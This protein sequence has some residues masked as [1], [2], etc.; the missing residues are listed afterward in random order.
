VQYSLAVAYFLWFISGFGMLGFH[1]FYLGKV[2]SGALWFLTGGF[3]LFGAIT[4]FFRLPGLVQEANIRAGVQAA[5]SYRGF[6]AFA[7][8]P[9]PA[10]RVKETP[11][12]TILRVAR[13]NGGSVTPGEVALEG[14]LSIEE[15]RKTLDKLAST[16]SAEMRVRSSGVVV[17]FFPE[18]AAEGKDD[19]A[20]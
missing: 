16:G 18:F 19:F 11:E 15:A 12:K 5:M 17:Y 2:G 20:V 13:K 3:F 10:A 7:P 6:G 8:A 14:D 1:R 4:D 9:P